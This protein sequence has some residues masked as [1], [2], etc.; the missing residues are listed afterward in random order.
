MEI[1]V[2]AGMFSDAYLT[3]VARVG[4]RGISGLRPQILEVDLG[5]A[6]VEKHVGSKKRGSIHRHSVEKM[7]HEEI[8]DC[9][10]SPSPLPRLSIRQST[11]LLDNTH[12]TTDT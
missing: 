4:T 11:V 8:Q 3:G 6:C 12:H 5:I 10:P 9:V 7:K 1:Y 2:M